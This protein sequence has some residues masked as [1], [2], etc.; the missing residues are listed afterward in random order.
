MEKHNSTIITICLPK[1]HVKYYTQFIRTKMAS[2][3]SR[4]HTQVPNVNP[5]DNLMRSSVAVTG[6][7]SIPRVAIA[8]LPISGLKLSVQMMH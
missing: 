8:K 1:L 3:L 4:C 7:I 5:K 6:T 2:L